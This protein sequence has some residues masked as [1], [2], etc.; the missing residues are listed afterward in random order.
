M[1]LRIPILS[2]RE[3]RDW[4]TWTIRR[5]PSSWILMEKAARR[6][7][8]LVHRALQAQPVP[9]E[10]WL[11]RSEFNHFLQSGSVPHWAK[12]RQWFPRPFHGPVWIFAGEGNNGGDAL[13]CARMLL[14]E[15][16]DVH[17]FLIELKGT[18]TPDNQQNL[19]LFQQAAETVARGRFTFLRAEDGDSAFT[20]L[21]EEYH[22]LSEAFPP[23]LIDGI[24]GS[25]FRGKL[26]GWLATLITEIARWK[27]SLRIA[28][29]IPSGL[30]RDDDQS[31]LAFPADWVIAFQS[32]PLSFF[33][34]AGGKWVGTWTAV[35]IDLH[36]DFLQHHACQ[37]HQWMV[38]PEILHS[39]V[40]RG[41]RQRTRFAHKGHTGHVLVAG[42]SLERGGAIF[43]A[44][45]ACQQ[46]GPGLITTAIPQVLIDVLHAYYPD[47][48]AVSTGTRSW[49]FAPGIL[50]D[51]SVVVVGPGMGTQRNVELAWKEF[52]EKI[53]PY[54]WVVLD[55][56]GIN[57]LA[58]N[59]EM[60]SRL[61]PYRTVL[62][63]HPGELYRLTG[64]R[65]TSIQELNALRTWAKTHRVFLLVKRAHTCLLTPRGEMWF[66]TTG[67]PWMATG[68]A[69]DTLAGLMGG[70][71]SVLPHQA[72]RSISSAIL[73][74]GMAAD[75]YH[76]ERGGAIVPPSH[77]ISY[78]EKVLQQWFPTRNL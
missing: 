31:P 53:R 56:D 17:V 59:P 60:L 26:Q 58:K 27:V 78:L 49:D 35:D 11:S 50:S 42:G 40:Q 62:T 38:L 64:Y 74:H 24:L 15:G 18:R 47:L 46:A 52:L 54:Q 66:H 29:D 77:L 2:A 32:P 36:P 25:G 48:M 43:L 55:A 72:T 9:V 21:R 75:L 63:P 8:L 61:P 45:R 6:W 33:T 13:A 23:V 67:N 30:A 7:T 69:G 65:G 51:Y 10:I 28:I 70:M 41:A 4:D 16:Y 39:W 22:H 34:P 20:R 5:L 57:L 3:Q 12:Y 37:I 1:H 68:G 73:W 71:L 19:Y 76:L 14:Q 44:G